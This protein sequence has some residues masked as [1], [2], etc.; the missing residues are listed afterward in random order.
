MNNNSI[1]NNCIAIAATKVQ[2][3]CNGAIWIRT[4]KVPVHE[5]NSTDKIVA[6]LNIHDILILFC[7]LTLLEYYM[8]VVN[9]SVIYLKNEGIAIQ[10]KL[11]SVFKYKTQQE[12]IINVK[13]YKKKCN[14][15]IKLSVI[16][17]QIKWH[18]RLF[19]RI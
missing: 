1:S 6:I 18:V 2:N 4:Y 17:Y 9:R 16:W 3:Q 10:M 8:N 12:R 19:W 15:K 13:I 7:I 14:L 11:H 5:W